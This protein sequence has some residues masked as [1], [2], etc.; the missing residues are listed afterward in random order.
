MPHLSA[1]NENDTIAAIATAA[2]GGVGIVRISGPN[3]LPI[4]SL[5]IKPWPKQPPTHK[6]HL[7]KVH[8]P[9]NHEPIDEV[10][11]CVMRAP[12]S[13]TGEDVAEIHG[14]GGELVLRQVL[15]AVLLAGA[16][17]A[18]PGEFTKR[19][20]LGGKID[21]TR[22][23]AVA[24]LVGA[25]SARALESAK[26]LHAGALG[27]EID[28]QR[29]RVVATLAELNGSLD[30]PEDE[31]VPSSEA[32]IAREI[33]QIA[34]ELRQLGQNCTENRS[35]LP[36]VSLSGPVN[37]GKSSLFNRLCGE[38]RAIV[39]S[40]PGTTRDVLQAEIFLDGIVARLVDT[41]G[42]R[43]QIA[44]SIEQLGLELGRRRRE[45]SQLSLLIVDGEVGFGAPEVA[46]WN[47][48][49]GRT[50]LLVWN[51]A[52]LAPPASGL[53]TPALAISARSGEGIS[54][55]RTFIRSAL[56]EADD[57]AISFVSRRH[58]D[59]LIAGADKLDEGRKILAADGPA[60]LAAVSVRGA[61]NDLGRI[62][63]ETFDADLLDAI[64]SRFCIGK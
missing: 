3:A 5:L 63:G 46:L 41:A 62:T 42:E 58:A 12:N 61:L 55:L 43:E 4:L 45:Q 1:A 59:A 6:L 7:G 44:G 56:T 9:I 54:E 2:G 22:A 14:H 50:R 39:D 28:R 23:E 29:R 17:L 30:F 47:A 35:D 51:K 33:G 32:E 24:D 20:F 11:A 40:A 15:G 64:F 60:E 8:H 27:R 57:G 25:R 53:P 48:L 52:D 10:L 37:A 38:E 21:L 13:Y 49:D 18:D 19:A 26:A 34:A 16:R 31:L 36:E